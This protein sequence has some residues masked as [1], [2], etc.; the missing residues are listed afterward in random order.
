MKVL[1]LL[2]KD[3]PQ[4]VEIIGDRGEVE[5]YEI[6]PA[7]KGKVGGYFAR[8]EKNVKEDRERSR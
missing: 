6:R 3:L 8:P 7:G 5:R 2:K 4:P 1:R